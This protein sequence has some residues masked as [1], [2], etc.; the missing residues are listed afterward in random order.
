MSNSIFSSPLVNGVVLGAVTAGVAVYGGGD[1]GIGQALKNAIGDNAEGWQATA[2]KVLEAVGDGIKFAS[3]KINEHGEWM[4]DKLG[5]Q[6]RVN[7]AVL[8]AIAAALGGAALT[9]LVNA[10]TDSTSPSPQAF[11]N[12]PDNDGPTRYS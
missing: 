4:V 9:G 7:S 2:D 8:P 3:D 11:P 10:A 6:D 5:L 1:S 12:I